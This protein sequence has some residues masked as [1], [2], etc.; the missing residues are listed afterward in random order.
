M[1]FVPLSMD[2]GSLMQVQC[3]KGSFGKSLMREGAGVVR[4]RGAGEDVYP[5]GVEGC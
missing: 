2:G 3:L 4:V 1:V 5:I